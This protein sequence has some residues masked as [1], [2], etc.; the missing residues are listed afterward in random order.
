[1]APPSSFK[2]IDKSAMYFEILFLA[3]CFFGSTGTPTAGRGGGCGSWS[4][5]CSSSQGWCVID[6]ISG[7]WT[8]SISWPIPGGGKRG[9]G[10]GVVGRWNCPYGT[11]A[12]GRWNCPYSYPMLFSVGSICLFFSWYRVNSWILFGNRVYQ[13]CARWGQHSHTEHLC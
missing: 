11:G 3:V 7:W 4:R 1:M 12:V 5:C 2:T 8:A 6:S 13:Y 9:G 10:S